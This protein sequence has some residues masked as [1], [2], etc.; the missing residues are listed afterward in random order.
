MADIS[1]T[2]NV[3]WTDLF[4]KK[5]RFSTTYTQ[6]SLTDIELRDLTIAAD[7]TRTLWDPTTDATEAMSTF[8]GCLLL[9]DGNLDGEMDIDSAGDVGREQNSFRLVDG[10]PYMLGAD[11]AYAN[12]SVGNAFGGTLDVFERIRVDEPAT[13]ARKLKTLMWA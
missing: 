4:G 8:T 12:H 7:A 9:S 10:L 11:D 1:I 5:H 13:A 3:K 2:T 6:A